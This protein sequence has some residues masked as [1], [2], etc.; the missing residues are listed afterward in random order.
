MIS[1]GPIIEC[2]ERTEDL[3]EVYLVLI[4]I[5]IGLIIGEEVVVQGST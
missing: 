2:G 4:L 1:L 5:E 3:L